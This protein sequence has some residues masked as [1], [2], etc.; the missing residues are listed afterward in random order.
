MIPCTCFLVSSLLPVAQDI[1]FIYHS[2]IKFQLVSSGMY[3]LMITVV[4]RVLGFHFRF[5]LFFA[6][7]FL[8]LPGC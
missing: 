1:N 4:M 8:P 6:I 7:V 3:F 2:Y 5:I